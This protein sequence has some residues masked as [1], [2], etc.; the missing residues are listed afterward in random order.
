MITLT[1]KEIRDLAEAA[2]FLIEKADS[3]DLLDTEMTIIP[4]PPDGIKDDDDGSLSRYKYVA[5]F[6]DYPEEGVF[7]LGEE[8][9]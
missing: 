1:G 4:C 8:L 9:K 2:G 3:D 7:G 5:Y 6:S